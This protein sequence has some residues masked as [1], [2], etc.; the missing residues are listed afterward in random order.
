MR[1]VDVILPLPLEG[2]FSY[3]VDDKKA[4]GIV[5]GMRLLVPWGKS[6]TVAALCVCVHDDKPD[7]DDSKIKEV[8]D[9]LDPAPV[10][11]PHQYRLWQWIASY[12]MCT[13]GEVMNAALPAGLKAETG[14]R[15][16]PQRTSTAHRHRSF[17]TNAQTA[18]SV[19]RLSAT[20]PLE[21]LLR[22]S[23]RD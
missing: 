16:I 20:L 1:Y 18:E 12:Y 23:L 15:P 11:L 10:I 8:L 3:A 21:P 13:M 6:K 17:A 14:Y 9:V 22:E 2:T 7:L 19:S 5:A 4:N